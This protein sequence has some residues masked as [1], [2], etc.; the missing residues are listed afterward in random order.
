MTSPQL[1]ALVG[2][3]ACCARDGAKPAQHCASRSTLHHRIHRWRSRGLLTSVPGPAHTAARQRRSGE[4]SGR[5]E[6]AMCSTLGSCRT[7]RRTSGWGAAATGRLRPPGVPRPHLAHVGHDRTHRPEGWLSG[8]PG[9][10]A[11]ERGDGPRPAHTGDWLGY[12]GACSLP[13]LAN[14]FERCGIEFRSASRSLVDPR[15][16][17]RIDRWVQAAVVRASLTGGCHGPLVPRHVRRGG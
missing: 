14:A 3:P 4:R 5:L 6:E 17:G 11:A 2:K 8:A 10:C 13:E 16:W 1:G 15:A 12:C 7:S 9:E